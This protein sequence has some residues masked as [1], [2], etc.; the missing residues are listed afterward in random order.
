VE[1]LMVRLRDLLRH[2]VYRPYHLLLAGG[3]CGTERPGLAVWDFPALPL[4]FR[5]PEGVLVFLLVAIYFT[6]AGVSVT[7]PFIV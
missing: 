7:V 6:G 2:E 5:N 4:N 1:Y 3:P